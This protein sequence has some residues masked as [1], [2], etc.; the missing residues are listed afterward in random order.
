MGSVSREM[1]IP[2]MNQKEIIDIFL[3]I[4]VTEMKNDC[5]DELISSLGMAEER[6]SDFEDISVETHMTKK[7]REPSLKKTEQK[8][9][10]IQTWRTKEL[11]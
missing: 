9:D 3:K 10:N 4:T 1:G 2:R 7:Q 8:R 11:Q 6:I 5:F